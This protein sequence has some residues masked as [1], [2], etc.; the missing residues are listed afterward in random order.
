MLW[1]FQQRPTFRGLVASDGKA[2]RRLMRVFRLDDS[3]PK[4]QRSVASHGTEA[5]GC[6]RLPMIKQ[7]KY[8]IGASQYRDGRVD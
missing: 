4:P 2:V 3:I 5:D 1:D 7:G 8:Y 6:F